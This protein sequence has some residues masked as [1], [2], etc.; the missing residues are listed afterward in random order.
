MAVVVSQGQNEIQQM[1]E[2]GLDIR[3]H[4]KRMVTED[5]DTKF[6]DPDDPFRLVFVCAMW[7]T[8]FDVPNCSTLYLDKPMRNHTLMQTIARANRVYADKVVG[9]IVDYVGVFRNLEKALAIYGAGGTGDERPVEDK[10]ALVEALRKTLEETGKLCQGQGVYL[11]AIKQ[12]EGFTRI[13]LLDDAVEALVGAEEVKRR[14]LD[15]ANTVRRLYKAVLPDREARHFALD[16]A[17]IHIIA[18]KIR[19]LIP[20]DDISEVM[21]KVENMLDRSIAIEGYVIRG[22]H[23]PDKE[24]YLIDLSGIDFDALAKKFKRSRK[25]TLTEQLRGSIA[26]KLQMMVRHNRMRMDYLERFQQ[27]IDAYNAGS[28]N[29]EKFFRQLME[30][31]KSLDEEEKRT[32]TEQLSEEELALFDLLTKP[33]MELTAR[34]RNEVKKAARELLEALKREKL[35]L[36]WRKR[37]QARAEVKVTIEKMLDEGLPNAYTSDLFETKTAAVFQHVYECYYGAGKSVYSTAA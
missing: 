3:S 37:Q 1:E 33:E 20:P 29:V 35:V 16:V 14:Y 21:Q 34:E 19:G 5:L 12:A 9:L 26:R 2:K 7:M 25:R 28:V 8:G 22:P 17:P 27:M 13:G 30:F 24:D 31:A 23:E 10:T 18:E 6:K 32:V 4:R 15:I 36:D 11:E